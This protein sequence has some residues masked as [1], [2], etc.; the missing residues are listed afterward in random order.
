MDCWGRGAGR[1]GKGRTVPICVCR[2]CAVFPLTLIGSGGQPR[3]TSISDQWRQPEAG[4]SNSRSVPQTASG[5]KYR[6]LSIESRSLHG[7]DAT[8][9]HPTKE[10]SDAQA[11]SVLESAVHAA[12]ITDGKLDRNRRVRII[13]CAERQSRG[14]RY[15][16]G[17]NK[18]LPHC[19]ALYAHDAGRPVLPYRVRR[20]PRWR[21]YSKA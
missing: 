15:G 12:T 16:H 17:W 7:T 4:Q 18:G 19:A 2:T 6:G 20:T 5:T 8:P 1:T 13:Y 21:A 10:G 3:P 14:H 9:R 11:D